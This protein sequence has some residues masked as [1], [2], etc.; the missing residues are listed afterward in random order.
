M[1]EGQIRRWSGASTVD[2]FK[3]VTFTVSISFLTPILACT[4]AR[5]VEILGGLEIVEALFRVV[6]ATKD[7]SVPVLLRVE[8]DVPDPLARGLV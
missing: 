1:H 7:D 3:P 4:S 2:E 6:L 8:L 5:F